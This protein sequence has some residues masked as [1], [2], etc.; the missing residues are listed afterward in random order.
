LD[1]LGIRLDALSGAS[2]ASRKA[3]AAPEVDIDAI[4]DAARQSRR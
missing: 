2:G 4:V 3:A 1:A